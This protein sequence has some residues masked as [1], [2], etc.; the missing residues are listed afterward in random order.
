MEGEGVFSL[1]RIESE[2][3]KIKR[4]RERAFSKMG[5]TRINYSMSTPSVLQMLFNHIINK[6]V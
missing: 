1:Y 3:V 2:E 4:E 6:A 5:G